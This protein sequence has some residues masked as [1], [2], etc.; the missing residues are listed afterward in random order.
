MNMSYFRS[1]IFCGVY[2]DDDLE[3]HRYSLRLKLPNSP[4]CS[5]S[6][7]IPVSQGLGGQIYTGPRREAFVW[8]ITGVFLFYRPLE[9]TL[10]L[11]AIHK[12][13]LLVAKLLRLMRHSYEWLTSHGGADDGPKNFGLASVSQETRRINAG[14]KISSIVRQTT[15]RNPRPLPLFSGL[16]RKPNYRQGKRIANG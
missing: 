12:L 1:V 15:G 5:P 14:P 3:D 13:A 2:N 6:K 7:Y 4:R 11:I 8:V 9:P 16:H 10:F